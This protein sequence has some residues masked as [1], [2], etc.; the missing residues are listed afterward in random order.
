VNYEANTDDAGGDCSTGFISPARG[1]LFSGRMAPLADGDHCREM[2]GK[3]RE[4]ARYTRSAGI[5]REL[6]DLAKRYDRRGEYFDR[7]SR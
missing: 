2:A 3:V 7:H 5:R 1:F 4:L 6:V